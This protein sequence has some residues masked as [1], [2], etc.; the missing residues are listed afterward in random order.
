MAQHNGQS[1]LPLGLRRDIHPGQRRVQPSRQPRPPVH[2]SPQ[3]QG[4]GARLR[5]RPARVIDG[6]DVA[7]DDDGDAHSGLDLAHGA[8]IGLAGIEL[9]A[10]AAVDGHGLDPER[11]G[12]LRQRGRVATGV[13]PAQAHLDRHRHAHGADRRL[14]QAAGQVGGAHQGRAAGRARDLLGR[15]AEIQVD[16]VCARALGHPRALG[17][18]GGV[19]ADQL[20]H[21]QGQAV[22]HRRTAHHVGPSSRQ[23][24]RGHHF[25]RHIGRAQ[26]CGQQ[27]ERQV[28]D[29]G[30]GRRQHPPRNADVADHKRRR[31]GRGDRAPVAS[32]HAQ[33][34]RFIPNIT[35]AARRAS[36]TRT[37]L[38]N[39]NTVKRTTITLTVAWIRLC[40]TRK[41][42]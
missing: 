2:S 19:T 31:H 4:V 3:H 27:P 18:H 13:V 15:A 32:G 34:A 37:T 41:P 36:T 8:P 30:H 25:R 14:D 17:H 22:A 33:A 29:P 38:A 16:D 26:P 24:G 23:F 21:R 28:R 6:Q 40:S 11:L 1:L 10:G 7:V 5:Q 12:T 39:M 42:T 9:L 20:D 35:I